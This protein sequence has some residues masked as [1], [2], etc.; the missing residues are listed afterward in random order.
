M[1]YFRP[2]PMADAA[3]PAGALPLAGGWLWFDRV[4]HLR[5]GA[6]P[7]LT[8]APAMIV[9]GDVTVPAGSRVP[10]ERA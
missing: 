3:R 4:E 9:H 1:S 2:I 5:R 8:A 6:A 10:V 7:E